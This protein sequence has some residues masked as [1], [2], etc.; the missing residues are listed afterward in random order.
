M[1]D[2][3]NPITCARCKHCLISYV[4]QSKA[5]RITCSLRNNCEVTMLCK[6]DSFEVEVTH[7]KNL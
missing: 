6:C 2:K 1:N 4:G 7:T 5:L 3:P